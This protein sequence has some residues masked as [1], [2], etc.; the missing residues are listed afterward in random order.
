VPEVSHDITYEVGERLL[1]GVWLMVFEFLQELLFAGRILPVES[2]GLIMRSL[3]VEL[4]GLIVRRTCRA[5]DCLQ[6]VSVSDEVREDLL[7]NLIWDWV[8]E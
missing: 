7:P 3:P 8:E 2:Q 4:R 1:L 6:G 5:Y